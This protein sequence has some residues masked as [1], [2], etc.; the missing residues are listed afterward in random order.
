M[1]FGIQEGLMLRNAMLDMQDRRTASQ[2]EDQYKKHLGGIQAD[3]D[4]YNPGP[5][6]DPKALNQARY[7]YTQNQ[8][9]DQ[10][11]QKGVFENKREH[12]DAQYDRTMSFIKQ[13]QAAVAIN[14]RDS[15]FRAYEGAY[16]NTFDGNDIKF[17]D[18]YKSYTITN[19][20][21][22]QTNTRSYSTTEEM[23]SELQQMVNQLG[24][25]R[26]Y[27][28][29]SLESQDAMSKLNAQ[30]PFEAQKNSKGHVGWVG[31]Q[32][33]WRTNQVDPI[34]EVEGIRIPAETFRKMGFM[35][36]KT[37][38]THAEADKLSADAKVA[39]KGKGT[40]AKRT[41][42]AMEKDVDLYLR[43]YKGNVTEEQ[44]LDMVRQERANSKMHEEMTEFKAQLMADPGEET[45]EEMA[46][47]K[48][49]R[50][51]LSKKYLPVPP[52]HKGKTA[53]GL[54]KGTK[55]KVPTNQLPPAK[56]LKEGQTAGNGQYIIKDGKWTIAKK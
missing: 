24:H 47:I 1:G 12:I 31:R 28:Q 27:T 43:I 11:I 46:Q 51:E 23:Q 54:P 13:S 3:P 50:E 29:K 4:N 6:Y 41:I 5:G 37:R 30:Q 19:A 53:R 44:A 8:L 40:A 15:E 42:G 36:A 18:D 2:F 17:S 33:N 45:E 52:P 26:E 9:Q 34:Y 55:S 35:E 48:A 20:L 32:Y 25:R 49:K 21:T 38:K 10:K 7:A 56:G 22:G 39:G 16:E 14:D